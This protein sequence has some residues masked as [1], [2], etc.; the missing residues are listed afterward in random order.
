[1]STPSSH[2]IAGRNPVREALQRE[3]RA[4]EK[5][6]L[7]QGAGGSAIGEIRRL[8][9]ESG[10]PVQFVP[11]KRLDRDAGGANHQGV[12]AISAPI[13]YHDLD[14]MLSEIAA[15][16]DVVTSTRPVLIALDEIEDPYNFGAILRSAVGS[17]AAGVIVPDRRM[18]PLSAVV[19]KASAGTADRLPIAR[20]RNL[21][22]G[23]LQ[24]KERGYWVAGLD[25]D[26]EHTVWDADWHRPT[27]IVVGSEGKGLRRRVRDVCD[28]IVTIPLRGPVESLNASVASGIALFAAVRDR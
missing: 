17:G 2:I 16:R 18:A 28:F 21:A 9:K 3:D 8:A 15:D 14:A 12:I 27:I 4:I 13:G 26:G 23:L 25:A 6:I 7:V 19:V 10:V 1:M 11:Q 5:I 20:V 24:C 22:D